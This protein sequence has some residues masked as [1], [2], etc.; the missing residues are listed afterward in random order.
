MRNN[1]NFQTTTPIYMA[2]RQNAQLNEGPDVH[3]MHKLCH[4]I[5][6]RVL[7]FLH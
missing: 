1:Y 2:D 7:I 5:G 4:I 6:D 3:S